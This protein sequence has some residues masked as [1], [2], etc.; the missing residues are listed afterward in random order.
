[1][2]V[3]EK[4][5][6]VG[7]VFPQW[8]PDGRHSLYCVRGDPSVAGVWIADMAAAERYLE[9]VNQLY[10]EALARLPPDERA[11]LEN[12]QSLDPRARTPLAMKST[13]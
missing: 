12:G 2:T 8:L 10:R 3:L 5:L 1:V 11:R 9:R 7:H 6:Q 13:P 4:P